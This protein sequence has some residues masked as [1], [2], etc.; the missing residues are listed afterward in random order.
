MFASQEAADRYA[1]NVKPETLDEDILL[2]PAEFMA[3]VLLINMKQLPLRLKEEAADF[4]NN[5]DKYH[6]FV[7]HTQRSKT[8]N[9]SCR[10]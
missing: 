10:S 8:K 2:F 3:D 9:R 1:F 5:A 4:D 7:E 6:G